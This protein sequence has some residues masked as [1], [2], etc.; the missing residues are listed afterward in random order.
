LSAA[1]FT[2]ATRCS[3]AL[4]DELTKAI[5]L[6][7][8]TRAA[9]DPTVD[10]GILK[11]FPVGPRRQ[12][13]KQELRRAAALKRFPRGNPFFDRYVLAHYIFDTI[14]PEAAVAFDEYKTEFLRGALRNVAP[15]Y[16][17]FPESFPH[18]FRAWQDE[19]SVWYLQ[20]ADS[21]RNDALDER[22]LTEADVVLAILAGRPK[23]MDNARPF[24]SNNIAYKLT[25]SIV[26]VAKTLGGLP[27]IIAR[28]PE[29]FT[30]R[31]GDDKHAF[32]YNEQL[33]PEVQ[34]ATGIRP[35]SAATS[36]PQQT[37]TPSVGTTSPPNPS[38]PALARPAAPN[39]A[40]V[41]DPWLDATKQP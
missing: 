26:R 34:A 13:M 41:S 16:G 30:V 28:H 17:T 2:N 33:T 18:L 23:K 3:L 11:T 10:L 31:P 15:M 21:T 20:R 37:A 32:F 36:A 38:P 19:G 27:A 4:R 40:A 22:N 25:K 6:I 9:E 5:V 29:H 8:R 39:A 12:S 1:M 24:S 14:P 35:A 7:S